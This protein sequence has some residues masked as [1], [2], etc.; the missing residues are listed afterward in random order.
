MGQAAGKFV[1][2]YMRLSKTKAFMPAVS[3]SGRILPDLLTEAKLDGP[4]E[5][6]GT[7]VHPKGAIPRGQWCS[8]PA[9]SGWVYHLPAQLRW[10]L[11]CHR[12]VPGLRKAGCRLHSNRCG[13][14]ACER[15]E[16][17]YQYSGNSTYCAARRKRP[18]GD[19]RHLGSSGLGGRCRTLV[20][21]PAET[22]QASKIKLLACIG[23]A[24]S[25][26]HPV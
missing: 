23:A 24:V 13:S 22:L 17:N 19:P 26:F 15:A 1:K 9:R 4:N 8:G 7:R 16:C 18:C 25:G 6:R 2:D 14:G 11:E 10:L 21:P 12:H 5:L 3:R 20:V